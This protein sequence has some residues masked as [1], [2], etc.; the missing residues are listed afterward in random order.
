VK[1][2]LLIAST[3][4]KSLLKLDQITNDLLLDLVIVLGGNN[5]KS[6]PCIEELPA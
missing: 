6:I 1:E 3:L 4:K 5:F 2:T